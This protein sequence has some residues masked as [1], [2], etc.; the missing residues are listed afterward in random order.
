MLDAL[1]KYDHTLSVRFHKVT[2]TNNG[3]HTLAVIFAR[4]IFWVLLFGLFI[5]VLLRREPIFVKQLLI[6]LT[7]SIL[8]GVVINLVLGKIFIRKR[9]FITHKL[10]ALISTTWLGGSFPSDH[11]M[12]SFAI[13][14]PLYIFDPIT[15]IWAMITAGLISLSRVAVGVHYLS[16][17]FTGT[18]VGT[19]SAYLVFAL[20]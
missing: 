9:P 20:I 13:A 17:I 1:R 19:A 10:H 15:G 2:S 4:W 18:L 6:V 7:G 11:A 5:V 12:L 8:F 16:D 3:I 14:S